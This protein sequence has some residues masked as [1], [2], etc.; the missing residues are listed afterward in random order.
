M[1][2]LTLG[3]GNNRQIDKVLLDEQTQRVD[4][5]SRILFG[6]GLPRDERARDALRSPESHV[7][8]PLALALLLVALSLLTVEPAQAQ[9]SDVTLS[10][11]T[12]EVSTDGMSFS[13]IGFIPE[14]SANQKTYDTAVQPSY[15]HVRL[16]PSANHAA[17]TLAVGKVGSMRAVSSGS[18]SA[19][20]ALGTGG[21]E[22]L[23]RVTAEDGSVRHYTL[24]V[25]RGG[26]AFSAPPRNVQV[27]AGNGSLTLTWEP[28]AYWGS[29]PPG[30]YDVDWYAGASPPT[31]EL[32]W[33]RATRSVVPL[34]TTATSY[35]F[36][37]TY[38]V[39]RTNSPHTV[40]NGTTYQLRLRAFGA[41]PDDSG[42][43]LPSFWV[44]KADSPTTRV[45]SSNADLSGLT[46][47]SATGLTDTYTSLT[48]TPSTFSAATTSYTATVA[49]AQTHAK[50]T[51]TVDDADHATVTVNGNAVTSGSE[52][53]AIALSQGDNA[54]TV[55]VTAEDRTTKDYTV[56]ITRQ[57][58]NAD[59]S[60][61]TASSATGLADTY[62]SLTLTP[63][64]FSAATTS[65]TATVANAQTH[66]KL[67]PTVDDTD[68]ATVTVNGNA[69][70]SGSESGA[71]ALS[72]GDNAITVRVTAEDRTTKDYTVTITRQSANADLSDLTASSATGLAD[73]YNSL[74]LTPSTFSAATTSYT[75]TVANA[76]TH[77]K[78]TPTVDDADHATVTV[79]GNAVTSGSESDAIALSQGDN[80]ITVRVTAQDGTTKD[81]T[82]TI[83]RAAAQSSNANLSGLT[84]SSATGLADTYTS[85]TLTPSTFSAART[86]YTATVA[87]ARTHAK[88][89]PTVDDIDHATVTVDGNAVTSGSASS[90][91]ALSVGANAITVRVMA[92]D[93]TTKDYTV[94]ITR[95]A[96]QSSNAD[97]SGLT[98]SSA[99]SLRGT[100]TT[101]TL[102]PT[103]S[104]NT[105][106]Y[107]A[108]VANA[109]THAKLTP[110]VDD[111]DHATVTVDGNAVASGSASS[112]ITLSVGANVI[113]VRVTAQNGTTRDYTVTITRQATGVSPT[114]SLSASPNPVEEGSPVTVTATLSAALASNVTI[115]LTLSS[116]T[117][118]DSDYGSLT[119]ITISS[120]S[121]TGTGTVTTSQD[122]DL[123]DETFTVAL[124]NLPSPV[125]AGSPSVVQV[126]ISDDDGVATTPTVSLS[127]SPNPVTE[128]SPVTVTAQLSSA[129]TSNVTI[130]L[131]LSSGTAEDD[132]YGSLTSITISSG[133]T[134]GTGT[135]TTSQDA[136]SDDETFTVVLGNLPSP[137]TA[138]SPNA[139]Q[140]RISDDDRVTTPTTPTVSLSA[141]PNPVEEGS[142]VT[143]T[144]TLS[145]ALASN[146]T[147]PLTLSSGTAEDDDYGSLTGITINSGSTTGTGTVTTSQDAD[148][149]DETFT[150]AL[151]NLP[152]SVTAGSPSLVQ[153]RISD[154]DRVATPA[155][156]TVSLSASP[157]P[158]AEGSSVTVTAQLSSALASNVTIPLTLSSETAEDDDYGSLSSITIN[159]GS[160]SGTGTVTTSQDADSQDETFTVALGN[161]PSSVTAGSPSVIKITITDGE[162]LNQAPTVSASCDPCRIGPGG[163]VHLA[164]Q[165][166]DP[167]G[168]ALTYAWSA[169]AGRFTG[170]ADEA[171]TRW[172][173]P[174]K[175][176]HVTIRVQVSDGR[177]GT[178]S[179]TVSI[180]VANAPPVFDEAAYAFELRENENGHLRPVPLG[181]VL[182]EDPDE[183]EVTY[184][185]ASGAGHLFAV[186]AQD[187][188]V[189]YVGP[190]EDHEVEPNRYELS[191]RARDTHGA[192]ARVPVVVEVVNVNEPPLAAADK[193]TTDEDEPVEINVLANDTDV[194]GDVLRVESVTGPSQGTARIAEDGGVLYAPATDWHGTD[195][196]VYTVTDG[197]GGT[198]TAEV[199]VVVD[200][201]NDAPEAAADKATT[202]EDE[203][204]EINVLANDTDVEGDV[205]RVE[206][207][208]GP[209]QG[210]ARIAE[211]GGVLY[212]PATDW[213]GTDRF[214]YTVTDGNGGTAT[215]EVEV[216]V[217]PVNDAPKA[218]GDT[219]RTLEDESVEI[220]VLANDIDIEGDALSIESV[221]APSHGTVRI[222]ENRRSGVVY[223]PYAD[224]HGT[225]QFVYTA[226]DGNGGTATA[227]VEV[228]V[229]PVNDAPE[230]VADTAA[231]AEDTK[232]VID[233]LANDMDVE[234][235][236]LEIESVSAPSNGT[237]RVAASGGVEYTPETDW[238]GTDGFIYTVTDGNGGTAKAEVVVE[239]ASVN[240]APEAMGTIPDQALEEGGAAVTLDI[241]PYFE[242]QDGDPLTYTAVSSDRS[243]VAVSVT[244]SSLTLTPVSYGPA[245]IEVTANDPGGL[246]AVQTF[247][248]NSSDHIVRT[249]LNETLAA[250]AR[251]HLASAR[252]T[253]SRRVGLGSAHARSRLTVRGR[254]IPL[255]GTGVRDAAKRLLTDWTASMSPN[256]LGGMGS[257]GATGGTEFLF[258]WGG[259]KA[260][261]QDTGG[262]WRVW[263][264]GDL[265]TFAGDPA[266]E[267]SYEGNLQ[268]V[269]AGVDRAL[270][271]HWLAGMAVARS[272]GG[273]DWRAGTVEGRLETSLTAVHPYLRWSDGATSVWAMA[274]GGRG[275]AE[276][277]RATGRLGES[278]LGLGLGLV[279][280]RRSLTGWF[281]LRADGA[282][283]RLATGAG[284]ESID[285]HSV[286]VDQ[287]RLGVELARSTRV[288]AVELELFGEASVRRD[289]G[290]GQ[291]GSGLEVAGGFRAAGGPVRLDTQVR[292]LVLHTAEDYEERGLA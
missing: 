158:V 16:T 29:F 284:P 19:A 34:A 159:S 80:A 22:I 8:R 73:T 207:V 38:T 67:T 291:N 143:V 155:T 90:A 3:L 58:A 99:T 127:A 209:S 18:P 208:T 167:D 181:T 146:V 217:D 134:T 14:F 256:H 120:G 172:A 118:E 93:G 190:G 101:L 163:E 258:A 142:P 261:V 144:A 263:G 92:Q 183:D 210:T 260:D 189:T 178:S 41:N 17:A 277:T 152:P 255:D 71:I 109:R 78:L 239:V 171:E 23:V 110:T 69:V 70:T 129:L 39:H 244:G 231:T 198:A 72:Q 201:V 106:S 236:A 135:V 186:G 94:T 285:G 111:T 88:L 43:H 281:A 160:T 128:G 177:G 180:E 220:D 254:A 105:T 229:D 200:P 59:L 49:N 175:I 85:L 20:I 248:V 79:G 2:R 257:L 145:A 187:G 226:A 10:G 279:E 55:R 265:Q 84:A 83:T 1:I 290:A 48:L 42:D 114:V 214:V 103:F 192:E 205:L 24:T 75:A 232:V 199:E 9:S 240:D 141:S 216:V 150:V 25:T 264:Q 37:G 91:I 184:A 108:T 161:L 247:A 164:A 123:D 267:R 266:P 149:D 140:V 197:N 219:A 28:P 87:N 289:G 113:T 15:S 26:R 259:D 121:T 269:W 68:H 194:E 241:A 30:G 176:G 65:Y 206:S 100:Y 280:V 221:T 32:D 96:A 130:P 249:V 117:A 31:D 196:F 203:P 292:A 245:S 116:G 53:G 56:T 250:M 51:P 185:L 237:A 138:G 89:T 218:L 66:A 95:E 212:A 122:A 168:D 4:P 74:T 6:G 230:A 262:V 195:R 112:A 125:T 224:W 33:N 119:S 275:T 288:G 174:T 81:Y 139:V 124:G 272:R 27:R 233:V 268:T 133:S 282:W 153:V 5:A 104:A 61:L 191:I 169:P 222:A 63:S 204:V 45:P 157:N 57:S 227:E 215:A 36:T 213:H 246:S 82:V 242:D 98:A 13:S 278:G 35:E 162:P 202:D 270:G 86:S 148:F 165:A 276:N 156:P 40:T 228:V 77:A 107:T 147:I 7:F 182:A 131:T 173:A 44:T 211:D 253:L 102:A 50:L 64:T 137:V 47:S 188:A 252:M 166:S 286:A 251:A 132:D 225:D 273:S 170:P 238:H 12:V 274:G 154:D 234:A 52:S 126:R 115:P 21:N 60:D 76:Q 62:N 223:T 46:A 283:A 235:D 151:G 243:V 179:A 271:E 97:L 11:L 136:D 54:I 287:Q 193:A